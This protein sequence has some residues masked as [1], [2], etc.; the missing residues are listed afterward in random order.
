MAKAIAKQQDGQQNAAKS[1]K[2]SKQAK[3]QAVMMSLISGKKRFWFDVLRDAEA[4]D[5]WAR[6][7]G[8]RANA[9]ESPK[10]PKTKKN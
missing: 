1:T 4:V 6:R 8:K 5:A 10:K 9:A 2:M 7:E 3:L